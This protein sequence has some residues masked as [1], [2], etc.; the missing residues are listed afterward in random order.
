MTGHFR[1]LPVLEELASSAFHVSG[2]LDITKCLIEA[3]S[4]LERMHASSQKRM[5]T[6]FSFIIISLAYCFLLHNFYS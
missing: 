1:H 4:R 2:M 5:Y 6:S 3:L